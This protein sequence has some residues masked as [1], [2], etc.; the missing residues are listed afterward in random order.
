MWV[1]YQKEERLV[2]EEMGS[3]SGI[4]VWSVLRTG[5]TTLYIVSRE[6]HFP[7]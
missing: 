7:G 5:S 6:D 1:N 2:M 4:V 3:A